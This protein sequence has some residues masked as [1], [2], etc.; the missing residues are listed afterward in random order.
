MSS[1]DGVRKVSELSRQFDRSETSLNSSNSSPPANRGRI[2]PKV[3]GHIPKQ[4]PEPVR[5]Q[6]AS[7]KNN[8]LATDPSSTSQSA[9]EDDVSFK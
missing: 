7:V 4:S 5:S 8:G 3:L 2:L 1:M 9:E 6:I